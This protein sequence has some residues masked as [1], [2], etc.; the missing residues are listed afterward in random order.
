[1]KRREGGIMTLE[2]TGEDA[3]VLYELLHAHLPSLRR[4]A[5]ATDDADLRHDLIV[6]E[7]LCERLLENL[8]QAGMETD[9]ADEGP[10]IARPAA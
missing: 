6:R 10:M 4:E 5:A 1:M 9:V 3:R 7:S 8:Q 2:L